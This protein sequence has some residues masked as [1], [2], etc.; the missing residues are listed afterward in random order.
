MKTD[1]DPI[2]GVGIDPDGETL[3]GKAFR[4]RCS[5]IRQAF[6]DPSRRYA[7]FVQTVHIDGP[8]ELIAWIRKTLTPKEPTP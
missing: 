2:I 1:L 4:F 3:G 8:D 6:R 5:P 7:D